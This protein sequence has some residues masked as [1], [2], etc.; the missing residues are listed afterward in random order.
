[1]YPNDTTAEGKEM[2]LMQE[3]FVSSATLRG[4]IRRLK[5]QQRFDVHELPAM[6]V[7]ELLRIHLDDAYGI[8][9]KVFSYT[10]RPLMLEAL[11][12]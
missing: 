5:H 3:Y 9:R 12:K 7:A 11:E 2:R 6:M 10:C 1:L 8:T 4:I